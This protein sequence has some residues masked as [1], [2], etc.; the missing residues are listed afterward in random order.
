MPQVV[1]TQAC[2]AIVLRNILLCLFK[3]TDYCNIC[4][5][6]LAGLSCVYRPCTAAVAITVLR[7]INSLVMAAMVETG[8]K[9]TRS[10]Q[11]K[12]A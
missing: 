4:K 10:H 5:G 3:R 12:A 6:V 7:R 1:Q 11:L 9:G 2:L 8:E